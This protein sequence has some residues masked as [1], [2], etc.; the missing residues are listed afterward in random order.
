[1]A[2]AFDT[3]SRDPDDVARVFRYFAEVETPRLG[4]RVYTD[5][6]AGIADDPRLLELAC[7]TI[8]SQPPPNVFFAAVKH[9][10]LEDP[11]R[12]DEAR[13]LA[14]FYPTL[15]G[16]SIPDESAFPAFRAFCLAH[17]DELDPVLRS[18]RTQTCVVHRSAIMLPAIGTLPRVAQADGRVGLLEIG[19]AIGLNLRLD[20]Y[21]YVYEGEGATLTWGAE[22]ATP[23]LA[24]EIRGTVPLLPA[25]LEI[26]ARHGLELSP[27]DVDDPSAVRWLRALIWPEHVER[28][29]LMDEAIEVAARV[30]ALIAAGDATKDLE[31][32]VARLP[33]D[34]P[35]VVFAT[36]A[37]Y[38]IDDDGQRAIHASL[39]RASAAQ[40]IDFVTM[41]SN[42][43]GGC[44]IDHFAFEAG[45]ATDHTVLAQADSHGRWIEWGR[46]L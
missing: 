17:A 4:S 24:C 36:V 27:I 42:G 35:R 22:D 3:Y 18:G 31:D 15:S 39:A 45:G 38:Q 26:A 28:G 10:L 43:Q 32:A 9:L 16:G 46:Q 44:R 7:R 5:Y 34:A 1:M 23:R 29:R 21:R 30:P 12:S 14:R 40:P 2:P 13:A 8:P 33:A 20:H 11:E 25:R 6:C 37:L 41:E 19:P